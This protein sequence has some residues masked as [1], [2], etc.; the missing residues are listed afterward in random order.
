MLLRHSA[1]YLFA[2]GV[3]GL[4]NF[5]ALAVYT[6]LLAPEQYG[7]YALAIAI[8]GLV[9]VVVWQWLRL[10][11]LRFIS[12]HEEQ[13]HAFL[14]TL[15]AAFVFLIIVSACIFGL[16]I[17]VWQDQIWIGLSALAILLLWAQA[18]FELNLEL[19]RSQL[20]PLLYGGLASTKAIVA[21]TL[22]SWFAYRGF[23]AI[24]VLAGLLAGF[25]LPA[26]W[27][28][29]QV[30]R[31]VRLNLIDRK[32]LT[33]LMRY[34]L[35]LTAT[36]ALGF[37]VNSS[38][39]LLIGWLMDTKSTGLY[40][41]GYDLAAQVLGMMMVIINLAAYPVVVRK[42]EREGEEAARNQL[43]AYATLMMLVGLPVAAVWILLAPNLASVV[44]DQAYVESAV[45]LIP[46]ITVATLI[47]SFQFFYFDIAF[48]LSKQT[49]RQ[50][51]VMLMAAM[52]NLVFNLVWIPR[53]GLEGAA[54]ATLISFCV[55]LIGSWVFGR[56]VFRL[57][58]PS[59]ALK[60]FTAV[61]VMS[62]AVWSIAEWRGAF[63]LL[64][65]A[66]VAAVTYGAVV[67]LLNVCGVQGKL[68]I[69]YRML[70]K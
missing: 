57:P 60:I 56:R 41:V 21:I 43:Q 27:M 4:I 9:N 51:W 1:I 24:G 68:A 22:G 33:T 13:P 59:H 15:A 66:L 32:I 34:G 44:L 25:A 62:I 45:Q 61:L 19:A 67:L 2:R 42:L 48:Q 6:R 5:L 65:Q 50:I 58:M 38:D 55:G 18:W 52:V 11:L 70:R 31:V 30:W 39:R 26:L 63:A 37:V 36:F 16:V 64:V 23:G 54:Y 17:L 35:P 14:S 28:T 29:W 3:P 10:G 49:V 69:R 46:I 12:S 8:V 40:A 20:S 47:S 53:F 7:Y